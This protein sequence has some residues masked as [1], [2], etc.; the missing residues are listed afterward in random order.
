MN[1]G[2]SG[3]QCEGDGEGDG[4]A[5]DDGDGGGDGECDVV[6]DRLVHVCL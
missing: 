6:A 3:D 1:S 4:D 2:L 5:N